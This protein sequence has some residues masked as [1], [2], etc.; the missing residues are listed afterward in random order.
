[1]F[2]KNDFFTEEKV[3]QLSNKMRYKTIEM[4][5]N[6]KSAHLGSCLSCIDILVTLYSSVMSF[7]KQDNKNPN[8]DIF[9]L[10]K[11][12]AAMALYAV[13]SH[14]GF[15][16]ASELQTYNQNGSRLA[17]HP[18]A[19]LIPGI[20]AATG[21]LGHGLSIGIGQA[22]GLKLKNLKNRVFCLLS[23]GETNE[24]SVWEAAA[25]ASSLSLKNLTAIID[26]NKWQATGRYDEILGTSSLTRKWE[27]FGWHVLEI[28]GHSNREIYEAS[29]SVHKKKPTLILAHTIKGKG[30]KLMED[31]NN[32]HY[33][34]PTNEELKQAQIEL[35]IK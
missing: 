17:E 4:S 27:S 1:M 6:A 22:Y 24:G 25:L 14:F 31:D 21:S 20:E 29:I 15:I 2:I 9:I 10:S 33:R 19:N 3:K 5:C 28:N 35:G 13:L 23:D 16:D 7:D 30:I 34:S 11:G 26:Y 32:W 12:H 18:P 8:R